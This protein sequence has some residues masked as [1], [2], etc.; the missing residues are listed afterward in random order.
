MSN[1]GRLPQTLQEAIVFFSDDMV[2]LEFVKRLRWAEGE[3]SC[4]R[5]GSARNS[6]LKTR[7]IWKCKGCKRQFSVKL[8]TIFE[9]SPLGLDKWL[10]AIWLMAN[11]KNGL[12]SYEIHRTVG[13]TQKS[14]WFMLHRIRSA[15]EAGTFETPTGIDTKAVGPEASEEFGR[16]EE[17]AGR[18][19]RV[20]KNEIGVPEKGRIR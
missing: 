11:A 2:C 17:W 1:D 3:P 18:L 6:F 13:I 7:L 14:A 10:T 4:P 8:N 15:M 9:D 20:P 12:S 5:C 19:V 16:F